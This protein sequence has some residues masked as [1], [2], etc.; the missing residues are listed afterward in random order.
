MCTTW[1]VIRFQILP[2]ISSDYHSAIVFYVPKTFR[3]VIDWWLAPKE[4]H[5]PSQYW[6]SK[7]SFV[8]YPHKEVSSTSECNLSSPRSLHGS[9]HLPVTLAP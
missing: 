1:N 4:D 7:I 5:L 9:Y 3:N 8:I 6:V 2:V